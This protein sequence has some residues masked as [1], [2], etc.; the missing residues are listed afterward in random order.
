MVIRFKISNLWLACTYMIATVAGSL[1]L[2]SEYRQ[3]YFFYIFVMTLSLACVAFDEVLPTK[4]NKHAAFWLGVVIAGSVMAFRAQ[5]GIDDFTYRSM[6]MRAGDCSL[7]EYLKNDQSEKGYLFINYILYK[8]TGGNYNIAQAFFA[9]LSM[10][11]W[12]KAI[13]FYRRYGNALILL[14]LVW[15]HYYFMIMGAGLIRIFIAIPIAFLGIGYLCEK[16]VYKYLLLILVASLFHMSAL[17]M[18][19]FLPFML[20]K[21]WLLKHWFVGA[22]FLGIAIP[23]VYL[24]IAKYLV[25]LLGRKYTDY[26]LVGRFQFYFN[27]LDMLPVI[28][29]GIYSFPEIPDSNRRT[30]CIG[31]VLCFLSVFFSVFNSVVGLGRLTFYGNLGLLI[32]FSQIKAA[33]HKDIIHAG[34]PYVLLVYSVIYFIYTG[35]SQQSHLA[36]LFPYRSVF[37][38][39]F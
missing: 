4:H 16:R 32:I 12:G 23:L 30:Y 35:F 15:T 18:L 10:F 7:L 33:P 19:I 6:F 14:L 27:T 26:G 17:A 5:T 2:Q 3:T 36:A 37:G 21:D 24:A 20:N 28:I 29:L 11:A 25:P 31:L 13:L 9:Y 39:T 38:V 22:L 1:I 8:A 34:V